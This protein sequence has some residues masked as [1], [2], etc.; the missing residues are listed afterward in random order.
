MLAI[1]TQN[2]SFSIHHNGKKKKILHKINLQI[3]E[4]SIFALIGPNWAGKTT[5][6]KCI[7]G[8]NRPQRGD[9]HYFWKKRDTDINQNI[10]YA[11]DEANFY[12]YLTGQEHLYYFSKLKNKKHTQ[13]NI[14]LKTS[15]LLKIV[16]LNHAQNKKIKHYSK[17][18]KQRLG[19][20][21]SLINDP[22]LLLRDEPMNGLDPIGRKHIKELI[23]KLKED[24]K[25]IFFCS[26]I[27]SDVQELADQVSI[28]SKGHLI[29][30]TKISNLTQPLESF[31]L[32]KISNTNTMNHAL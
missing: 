12:G 20:A 29:S 10:G 8:L 11:P 13:Q 18:M 25:T 28:I 5:T 7:I 9:I 6:L 16:G 19:I 4:Q 1:Q 31:F 23:K 14:K 21:I 3:P 2:I 32:Q 17:G 15:K 22:S 27:L 24:G 30:T 26:H